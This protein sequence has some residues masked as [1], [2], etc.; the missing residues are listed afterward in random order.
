VCEFTVEEIKSVKEG[1]TDTANPAGDSSRS[2][3][4]YFLVGDGVEVTDPAITS[5]MIDGIEVYTNPF[6]R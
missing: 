4:Q 2:Y 3:S 1:S 5:I 6:Q